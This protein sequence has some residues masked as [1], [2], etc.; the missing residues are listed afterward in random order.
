M[1]TKKRCGGAVFDY[2][3]WKWSVR[4]TP[5]SKWRHRRACKRLTTL[6]NARGEPRC[7]QHLK[8]V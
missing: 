4:R 2:E 7:W 8:D 6:N 3:E 5:D 1:T